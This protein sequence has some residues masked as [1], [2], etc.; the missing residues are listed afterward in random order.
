MPM[1]M[2]RLS[3]PAPAIAPSGY[4]RLAAL[5]QLPVAHQDGRL[6]LP[7][8]PIHGAM[9]RGLLVLHP[10]YEE[11][12]RVRL[13]GQTR[14]YRVRSGMGFQAPAPAHDPSLLRS[15]LDLVDQAYHAPLARPGFAY[16]LAEAL[17]RLGYKRLA[18]GGFHPETLHT[19]V[20]RLQGLADHR[21]TLERLRGEEARTEWAQ[22]PFWQFAKLGPGG[23]HLPLATEADWRSLR[24]SDTLWVSPGAWWEAIELPNY[25]LALPRELFALPLDGQGNQVNRV[26]LQLAAELAVWERAE[27]KNGPRTL[28]RSVGALLE[29]ALLADRAQLIEESAKRLNTP[30]RLR[31]YLAGDGFADQG[32]FALLRSLGRFEIDIKDEAA[33]WASGRGWVERFWDAK[34]QFGV[35]RRQVSPPVDLPLASLPTPTGELPLGH[36]RVAGL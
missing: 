29:K 32:A 20:R 7:T 13:N 22:A 3:P 16:R 33:F 27:M 25:R 10:A 23:V 36:W 6:V 18:A 34:L 35:G 28:Q 26:A 2:P 24:A 5:A 17:E 8:H 15:H 14:L 4:C 31:E 19:H 9:R 21:L 11:Q 30:K 1:L 12:V